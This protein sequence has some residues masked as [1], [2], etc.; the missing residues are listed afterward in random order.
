MSNLKQ[1]SLGF[2]L[3]ATENDSKYPP[4]NIVDT[5]N[6]WMTQ[7]SM[8][9]SDIQTV[10]RCP[11]A[12]K[13]NEEGQIPTGVL[14]TTKSAWY[15][16]APFDLPPQFRCGSYGE[17]LYISKPTTELALE[18]VS[19]SLTNYWS[20]P[21]EKGAGQTPLLIDARW[22]IIAPDD[23]PVS[24]THLTLPTTPYV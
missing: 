20:G 4:T 8:Y 19:G 13:V 17:N 12:V 14:G 1:W 24:Y 16:S 6:I 2:Q 3:Y 23:T 7:L 18:T 5:T 22:Y 9:C 10:R 21:D 11:C 15:L